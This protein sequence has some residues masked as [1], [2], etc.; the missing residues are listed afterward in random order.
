MEFIIILIVIFII[1]SFATEFLKK[2]IDNDLK[3][4]LNILGS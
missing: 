4:Y 3:S 2:K 1:Y